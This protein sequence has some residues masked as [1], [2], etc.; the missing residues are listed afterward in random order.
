[1][2]KRPEPWPAPPPKI[3]CQQCMCWKRHEFKPV[4][5]YDDWEIMGSCFRFPPPALSGLGA[6]GVFPETY[7]TAW[8]GEFKSRGASNA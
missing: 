4:A 6:R 5:G 1:M 3:E 7:E 8:C 2:P